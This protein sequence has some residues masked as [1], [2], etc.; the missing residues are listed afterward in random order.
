MG[1]SNRLKKYEISKEILFKNTLSMYL[2]TVVKFIFR[3]LILLIWYQFFFISS[4]TYSHDQNSTYAQCAEE[5]SNE[6]VEDMD[7]TFTGW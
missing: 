4:P 3:N 2:M 6:S 5:K 7:G 1:L